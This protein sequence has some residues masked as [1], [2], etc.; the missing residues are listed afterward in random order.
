MSLDVYLTLPEPT[1]VPNGT[2][3]FVNLGRMAELAGIYKHLWRP[4]EIGITKARQ[5]IEPLPIGVALM[6]REPERFI[7][8]NP[9][10]GWGSYKDFV[11]W[12]ERY[13]A[14]CCEYPDA[15]VSVS[16]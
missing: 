15:E 4:D 1:R 10:N 8:L 9:T 2:G 16:R 11:P 7:A 5:L 6:N 14:A 3:I 13:I 12:I